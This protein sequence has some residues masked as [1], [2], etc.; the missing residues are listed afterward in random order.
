MQ[1]VSMK[2]NNDKNYKC[3]FNNNVTYMYKCNI[4]SHSFQNNIEDENFTCQFHFFES[5]SMGV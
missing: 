5:Q 2:Q 3:E 1:F 4:F